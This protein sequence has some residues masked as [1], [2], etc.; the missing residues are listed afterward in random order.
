MNRGRKQGLLGGSVLLVA[1][2][3]V[4]SIMLFSG[5]TATTGQPEEAKTHRLMPEN[6]VYMGAFRLPDGPEEYA[7]KYS[8]QGLAFYPDGDPGGADDGCPGSLFGTGHDWNQYVS[9]IAIPK[10]I[11]C[12][13]K[14]L[15]N[16]NTAETLQEFQDVRGDLFEEEM[17]QP[18][19]GLAYLPA[20]GEQET[21]KLYFCFG[22]HLHEAQKVPS[23]G[24]CEL[25]LSDPQSAGAWIVDDMV[26]YVTTDYLFPIDPTWAKEHVD[27]MA[28][29]TGRFRD[30]GQGSLGPTIVA[31]A[32][33]KDGNP[34]E[35]GAKIRARPLLMYGNV[36]QPPE[37]QH[38]LDD[39]HHSDDWAGAAW[40]TAGDKSAVV[41]VG[42]KGRGECWYGYANGVVWPQ[43]P[44]FPP[45]PDYPNDQRGWWS[46]EFEGRMLFYDPA[47][48]AAVAAGEMQPHEPQPYASMKLDDVFFAEKTRRMMRYIGAVAFD[49][50]TGLL[51][52]MELHGDEDKPLVHVWKVNEN[53]AGKGG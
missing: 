50:E 10:P 52:V 9:E 26:T 25:D 18:R 37:Q 4:V 36:Y 1:M 19:A 21:G 14:N 38:K 8:G 48:L 6:L 11:V 41:I 43:E 7:W 34:P 44:P 15:E 17:E 3:A 28:L 39:Y 42:T 47:D 31:I 13:S 51:Y 2:A 32:P 46:T 35:A 22:P 24:C 20:Q 30:G 53:T 16:L 27:G 29:A 5:D 45:V 40:L 23:H 49:R 33:W 12:R